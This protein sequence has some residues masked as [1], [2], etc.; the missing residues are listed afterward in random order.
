[1]KR[2]AKITLPYTFCLFAA[3]GGVLFLSSVVTG[4]QIHT[5]TAKALPKQAF[6]VLSGG[7]DRNDDVLNDLFRPAL[8]HLR[9]G[10]QWL[11]HDTLT[12]DNFESWPALLLPPLAEQPHIRTIGAVNDDGPL[13]SAERLGNAWIGTWQGEVDGTPATFQADWDL[14]GQPLPASQLP[15]MGNKKRYAAALENLSDQDLGARHRVYVDVPP[16]TDSEK[17]I[18]LA[19]ATGND[20]NQS[21]IVFVEL[22][23]PYGATRTIANQDGVALHLDPR[24]RRIGQLEQSRTAEILV[25]QAVPDRANL[26]LRT[27]FPSAHPEETPQWYLARPFSVGPNHTWWSIASIGQ[28]QLPAPT[29][30]VF[31]YALTALLVGLF[32]AL[33]VAIYLG[34]KIRAPLAHIARR[35]RTIREIDEHYVP[36]PK[37]RLTEVNT[38]TNALEEL[39]ETAVEHLDYHEAPLVVWAQPEALTSS[40]GI[41]DAQPLKRHIN[42]RATSERDEIKTEENGSAGAVINV[43][44]QAS[45]VPAVPT[46]QIQALLGTRKEVRRLHGQLAGA[47]EELRTADAHVKVGEERMKRQRATLRQIDKQFHRDNTI[48]IDNLHSIRECLGARSVA[49]WRFR[50][51]VAGTLTLRLSTESSPDTTP[52]TAGIVLR[53]LLQ[54]EPIVSTRDVQQDP[55]LSDLACHPQWT[56]RRCP[57]LIAPLRF[58]KRILGFLLVEHGQAMGSWKVDEETFLINCATQCTM[59][60]ASNH[61]NPSVTVAPQHPYENGNGTK[62]GTAP[63]SGH[64]NGNG[65]HTNGHHDEPTETDLITWE[66]DL[67]GCIKSIQGDVQGIYGYAINSLIGQPLTFLSSRE[68]G[69]RDLLQLRQVLSGAPCVGH[70]SHHQHVDGT[71]ITLRVWAEAQRDASGRVVGVRGTASIA[72]IPAL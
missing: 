59:V 70:E 51:G 1:M 52:I 57:M 11:V 72:S 16:S 41:V 55:R 58:R 68:E 5:D 23:T 17:T 35:A 22:E 29:L 56:E 27:L 6:Q 4:I 61:Q 13:W 36:W 67:A 28:D 38:L 60:I 14:H 37:S 50:G 21:A 15:P 9:T 66:T 39:Y 49:L 48:S 34:W 46:A 62:N 30:P 64:K 18:L 54:E 42:L 2:V 20:V 3:F 7:L 69:D 10:Q 24:G 53:A 25:E 26:A 8:D 31:R 40:D 12:R 43:A 47:C 32:G 65:S 45:G 19:M 63:A 44:G 33:I 71:T